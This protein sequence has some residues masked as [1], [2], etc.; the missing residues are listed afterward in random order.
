MYLLYSFL[1]TLVAVLLLPYFLFQALRNQK[2]FN[3]FVERLGKYSSAFGSEG[4]P[5]IWI[6][7]V[8]VGETLSAL[9]L[10]D[11]L[12]E[13]FPDH[14]I[15]VSTTTATGQAVARSRVRNA[16]AFLY[17]PFD[18]RFC[19]RRALRAVK[20]SLIVLMES[21][22]WP[23]FLSEC[24][25]QKIPVIVANGRVSER[26]FRRS[27][28]FRF[29]YSGMTARI[30]RFLMQTSGDAERIKA[31]GADSSIVQV[32]GNLKY[33]IQNTVSHTRDGSESL[34]LAL[35]LERG[36]LFIAGSTSE[37]EDEI[38][39]NAFAIVRKVPGLE[40]LRLLVAPRHPQR[41]DQVFKL[42]ESTA[43]RSCRRSALEVNGKEC[44]EADIILLDSI[45]ELAGIY[46]YAS[47][48]LVGGSLVPKGG[49]NIL[50]PAAEAKPVIVGP[51]VENFLDIVDEFKRR[52]AVVQLRSHLESELVQELSATLIR[53][54][55][56]PE[57]SSRLSMNAA[58]GVA[59]NKGATRRT[60]DAIAGYLF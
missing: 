24:E 48:V 31:L 20:P 3:N 52:D 44:A 14:R 7:A 54:L 56:D 51:F 59:E 55:K 58:R 38:V 60:V 15:I 32:S 19:V 12:R 47:V 43:F 9:P 22:L 37:N 33:D 23:N 30:S 49:H 17:F 2:Y 50:E 40:G 35:G 4:S 42:I 53:L 18:W 8:S 28:K 16:D 29:F 46:K 10:I 1:L 39:L 25:H 11:M 27:S 45:G 57:E 5:A 36:P 34:N 13:N 26:A 21:E 41:F 6:H